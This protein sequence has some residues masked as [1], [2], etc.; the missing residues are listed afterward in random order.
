[1]KKINILIV[2]SVITLISCKQEQKLNYKYSDREDLF[3]CSAIDMDLIKEA[4]Y[5]YEDYADRYYSFNTP[6]LPGDGYFFYWIIA[7]TDRLPA[8]EY[9]NPHIIEIRD[10]LKAEKNLW[11]TKHGKTTLNYHHPI[12]QCISKQLFEKHAKKTF[13]VLIDSN[14]FTSYVY[15]SAL[16]RNNLDFINDR[17]FATYLVLDTFYAR[18][19]NVDFDNIESS[20]SLNKDE[21]DIEAAKDDIIENEGERREVLK[22]IKKTKKN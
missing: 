14:T 8:I 2:L 17:A 12:I 9:I 13:D 19:L 7:N 22:K 4:V 3:S 21:A 10:L 6:K 16:N 15:L 5:A 1:M 20:M 11:V 18:I